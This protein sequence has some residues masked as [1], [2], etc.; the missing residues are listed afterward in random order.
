MEKTNGRKNA[1]NAQNGL[2]LIMEIRAG[3]RPGIS[4]YMV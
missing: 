2:S 1:Q 4:I 3:P